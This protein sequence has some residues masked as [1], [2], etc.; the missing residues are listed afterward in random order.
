[1]SKCL[2]Y[3]DL[4][5]GAGGFSLGF[6][7]K[8]F[9]NVFSIDIEPN[10]CKTY[11]Y[12]FPNHTLI[13]KDI[14]DLTADEL[15]TLKKNNEV[16]V[17]IGGPP[18]QG[19]SIAGNI[20]RKFID[21]PRNRLFSEF[22][23]VVKLIKP[24]FFVME[25]VAR[26]YNHNKGNTRKEIIAAFK[27]LGYKVECKTLNSA[28]YGVPQ[29]RKRLIF[30]GS[31]NDHRILFPESETE[32]YVTVK[33]ALSDYPKLKSGQDST[34]PNHIAMSHSE[35]M[36]N[37]MSFISDGGDRTEIPVNI[38]PKLG[39]ARKYIKYDSSKPSVT[40]TG[41]MRKIF[42]YEQNR[43][44]TVRELAKLQSFPDD[45]VFKGAKIS[46]QQQVGNSVPPKMAEAIAK[47]IIKMSEN[48]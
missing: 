15:K 14:R 3:I 19:F 43:A 33:D 30:I 46:Q 6:D 21:D 25:N 28:D 47:I 35:Q 36:L 31:T 8:G 20:G 40:V 22:A 7:K 24:K 4:F 23:R 13:Q 18:C 27:E 38:R 42:H 44:L 12:N 26:L 16:D 34:I 29:V 45:F 41:D 11:R 1:M 17:I 9:Q 48:A 32:K 39:D 5:S 37:K 10:F 2:K